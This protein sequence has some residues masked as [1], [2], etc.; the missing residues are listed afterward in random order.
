[1]TAQLCDLSGVAL[2]STH[3][4]FDHLAVPFFGQIYD[5]LV[6]VVKCTLGPEPHKNRY[7]THKKAPTHACT[8]CGVFAT[9]L[10]EVSLCPLSLCLS[11]VCLSSCCVHMDGK[12]GEQQAA[13]EL[14]VTKR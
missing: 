9:F 1:M 7:R 6:V 3:V 10:S 13:E 11:S 5:F 12:G 14:L 8:V 4:F 2:F